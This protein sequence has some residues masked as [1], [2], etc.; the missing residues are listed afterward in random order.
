MRHS[1]NPVRP[2]R[3]YNRMAAR[4]AD[5]ESWHDRVQPFVDN[6]TERDLGVA[7]VGP[8]VFADEG[9]LLVAPVFG[10]CFGW[11]AG[12]AGVGA[13]RF[14][15]ERAPVSWVVVAFVCVGQLLDSLGG[16]AQEASRT[17]ATMRGPAVC[18]SAGLCCASCR[19]CWMSPR[20]NR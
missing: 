1:T 3:S 7:R 13:V 8:Q 14:L 19:I 4:S 5:A 12:L 18:R 16:Q 11:E 20:V 17:Q 10:G 6:G 9:F 2:N 15:V